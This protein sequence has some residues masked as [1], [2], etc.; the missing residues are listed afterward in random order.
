[1]DLTLVLFSPREGAAARDG[2]RLE[3][4]GVGSYVLEEDGA[5]VGEDGAIGK[6]REVMLQEVKTV[7]GKGSESI[8]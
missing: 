7:D 8:W 5:F 2:R 6:D 4:E 3:E 1:M